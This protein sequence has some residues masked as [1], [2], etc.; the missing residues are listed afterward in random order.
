[1]AQRTALASRRA[2]M[3][4]AIRQTGPKRER[5]GRR[6][7][8]VLEFLEI[9]A[10]RV[11]GLP[12]ADAHKMHETMS[13]LTELLDE[14][15]VAVK[16]FGCRGYLRRLVKLRKYTGTLSALDEKIREKLEMLCRLYALARDAHV[17]GLLRALPYKLEEAL[18]KCVDKRHGDVAITLEEAAKE[19]GVD[20]EEIRTALSGLHEEHD[21]NKS[22]L[23]ENNDLL[24]ELTTLLKRALE[25]GDGAAV[26]RAGARAV[27]NASCKL[28]VASF[29]DKTKT[30]ETILE[31]APNIIH[32]KLS[33]VGGAAWALSALHVSA[34]RGN[35]KAVKKLK[36][37]NGD[38]NIPDEHQRTPLHH[39]A[40]HGHVLV[41]S[42]LLMHCHVNVDAGD[43]ND[44]T[45]L[46]RAS[47]GGFLEVVEFLVEKGNADVNVGYDDDFGD[48]TA[49]DF[50]LFQGHN[51]ITTQ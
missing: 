26:Q 18:L 44:R 32:K 8:G 14:F 23:N 10:H 43:R 24:K 4:A 17:E 21:E 6:V 31:K 38:F 45:A 30:I 20:P 39:A 25:L 9:L 27:E 34:M 2:E 49:I 41:V 3:K 37:M 1:M 5:A 40:A 19:S 29:A 42:Y 7:V 35:L 16:E 48:E 47:Y 36:N 46:M 12:V 28:L 50:A 15:K 13:E 22:L 11:E 33:V 51:E